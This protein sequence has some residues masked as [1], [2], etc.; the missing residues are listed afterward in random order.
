M[1]AYCLNVGCMPVSVNFNVYLLCMFLFYVLKTN[2]KNDRDT[3][4]SK[5]LSHPVGGRTP[6][7]SFNFDWTTGKRLLV[8]CV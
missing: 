3:I 7:V 2:H 1:P 8:G 4:A 5:G 6:T